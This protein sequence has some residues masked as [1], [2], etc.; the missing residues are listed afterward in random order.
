MGSKTVKP[1]GKGPLAYIK[2]KSGEAGKG[3][4]TYLLKGMYIGKGKGTGAK[5]VKA[6]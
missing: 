3:L 1:K 4:A 6:K 2:R 5:R